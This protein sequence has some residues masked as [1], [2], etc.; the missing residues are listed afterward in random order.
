MFLTS[1]NTFRS[2][3]SSTPSSSSSG[4][5]SST[6]PGTP[7]SK[8][9]AQEPQGGFFS[10]LL[11]TFYNSGEEIASIA[12][13]K[14][15]ELASIVTKK[16]EEVTNVVT[17][18]AEAIDEAA[19]GYFGSQDPSAKTDE[20]VDL[21]MSKSDSISGT[22]E[23]SSSSTKVELEDSIDQPKS[24]QQK[25]ASIVAPGSRFPSATDRY[26]AAVQVLSA[27]NGREFTSDDM[28]T[29]ALE[30]KFSD[31]Q[32]NRNAGKAL[33]DI[34]GN[35]SDCGNPQFAEI[36]EA[37]KN[38]EL[39]RFSGDLD[40]IFRALATGTAVTGA[41]LC[42]NLKR[43]GYKRSSTL[44]L[45]SALIEKEE[46]NP[47]AD[48]QLQLDT[49][50]RAR[51]YL[52]NRITEKAATTYLGF[53]P[54]ELIPGELNQLIDRAKD[55]IKADSKK[56]SE[57]QWQVRV[58][59]VPTLM[60][61]KPLAIVAGRAAAR[62][63]VTAIVT[64]GLSPA[65]VT[66][67]CA[68]ASVAILAGG[69]GWMNYRTSEAL[70]WEEQ[71]KRW[72]M[73]YVL[74]HAGPLV[75]IALAA[76]GPGIAYTLSDEA[77]KT[78]SY[79]GTSTYIAAMG[80][81]QILTK[82]GRQFVQTATQHSE[83]FPGLRNAKLPPD[84]ILMQQTFRDAAGLIVSTIIT[85]LSIYFPL[86][87]AEH[88]LISQL[89]TT[90][91][92]G[93]L[94]DLGFD[95]L[96]EWTA[97]ALARW[98]FGKSAESTI[99][100]KTVSNPIDPHHFSFDQVQ[101]GMADVV[102]QANSRVSNGFGDLLTFVA[103]ACALNDNHVGANIAKALAIPLAAFKTR[104]STWLAISR[105]GTG[106][107]G[108]IYTWLVNTIATACYGYPVEIDGSEILK[109]RELSEK[110]SKNITL[111]DYDPDSKSFKQSNDAWKNALVMT[112]P[113]GRGQF[114]IYDD[115]SKASDKNAPLRPAFHQIAKGQENPH[116]AAYNMLMMQYAES[117]I[118]LEERKY[119]C[120]TKYV[121]DKNG[122]EI[123]SGNID[124]ASIAD[125]YNKNS[126]DGKLVFIKATWDGHINDEYAQDLTLPPV[127]AFQLSL[128]DKSFG[129]MESFV[130]VRND[131]ENEFLVYSPR[132]Y[133]CVCRLR[134]TKEPEKAISEFLNY[135]HDERLKKSELVSLDKSGFSDSSSEDVAESTN[136]SPVSDQRND[137]FSND[138]S[139]DNSSYSERPREAIEIL[140][141][142][143][144]SGAPSETEDIPRVQ[145]DSLDDPTNKGKAPEIRRRQ[146]FTTEDLFNVEDS[147][148]GEPLLPTEVT[149]ERQ[150]Q[151]LSTGPEGKSSSSSTSE[152]SST[153]S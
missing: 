83:A 9:P 144:R 87:T 75:A 32:E 39:N 38:E 62:A 143:R 49:W 150:V 59:W 134:N 117:H 63:A 90:D 138:S 45:I 57:E 53:I 128:H 37:F 136:P 67:I 153:D 116:L 69:Y 112:L 106:N 15:G 76:A 28:I 61:Q 34:L 133:D 29:T 42:E 43:M 25:I 18:K 132:A 17:K 121:W 71:Q 33:C 55:E 118:P 24:I 27:H 44:D 31:A 52:V 54:K 4:T 125:Y 148:T 98:Y 85:M 89:L 124:P 105:N 12:T 151:I 142:D 2:S 103:T 92:Y 22:D 8:T 108:G 137:N 58:R 74:Q 107:P 36:G 91:L 50:S 122:K 72:S 64:S 20:N 114:T 5:P 147:R 47:K 1:S 86:S 70:T 14:A 95:D 104:R 16:A 119:K 97:V 80:L 46:K 19:A 13:K 146:K 135:F 127:P 100:L 68:F 6:P 96:T 65:W 84:K 56:P 130:F 131:E 30:W 48:R 82:Y 66:G 79:G 40:S 126:Q 152:S 113:L 140:Y 99:M 26:L 141:L 88:D 3:S 145:D 109:K 41:D 111:F 23:S 21:D 129:K 123:K 60:F 115:G 78:A 101:T 77:G 94:Q 11:Q 149:T 10:G 110:E 7:R 81:M 102:D 139:S 35:L 93:M 51:E 120:L 73:S